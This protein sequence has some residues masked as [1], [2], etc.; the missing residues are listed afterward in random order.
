MH[1]VILTVKLYQFSFKVGTDGSKDVSQVIKDALCEYI[2][3]IFG[4]EHQMNMCQKNAVSSMPNI[5]YIAHRPS[6]I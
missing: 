6:I 2:T 3:P 4:Y 5:S 1:V